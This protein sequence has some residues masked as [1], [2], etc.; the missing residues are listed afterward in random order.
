MSLNKIKVLFQTRNNV[1]E[2]RGGDTIQLLKTKEYI[3]KAFPNIEISVDNNPTIDLKEFDLVH[4]FNL[5]RPQETIRYVL[6]AKKQKKPVV[7]ST[8][9][10]K[11]E[12]FEKFGQIGFR[13]RLNKVLSYNKIERLREVFRFFE[14]ERHLGTWHVIIKGFEKT[15]IEILN[16]VDWLLPNGIGEINLLNKNFDMNIQNYTVVPNAVTFPSKMKVDLRRKKGVIC[17]G[18]IE[19]R[20]NQLNLVKAMKGLPFNLT[21]IGK[22]QPTQQKYFSLVKQNAGENVSFVEEMA[23]EKLSE[24]YKIAK[25][26]ILPSWYDTPGLVSLEAGVYGCNLIVGQEGT[27]HEYFG[28]S[29]EYVDP[30]DISNIREALL[31]QYTKS[32]NMKFSERISKHYSWEQ[33]ALKTVEGYNQVL[34]RK[35]RN[36]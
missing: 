26:H 36:I 11:S 12:K 16:N 8:I 13:N 34:D 35:Q 31:K 21:I 6:N 5:L 24:Y 29:A 32:N 2:R 17:V 18:R 27:T 14:G 3:E 1:F 22:A 19:P 9:Y 7:L 33:T 10:W 23:Q 20:K 15:Q 4:V 28:E 25:V 30:W